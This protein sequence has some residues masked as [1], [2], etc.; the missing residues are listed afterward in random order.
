MSFFKE[1]VFTLCSL[2]VIFS[3]I[4]TALPEGSTKSTVKS[5][6]GI[7]TAL[8]LVSPFFSYR[9][10]L[11]PFEFAKED[12]L[13]DYHRVEQME[14]RTLRKAELVVE[15][16][17]KKILGRDGEVRVIMTAEGIIE[18]VEIENVTETERNFISE[19][20]GIN[21]ERIKEY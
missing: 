18:K 1:Y 15:G 6:V 10:N 4:F 2:M 16:E 7:V 19:K 5:V 9:E 14:K 17:I 12:E 13:V 21:K 20:M 8:A 3:A 11:L